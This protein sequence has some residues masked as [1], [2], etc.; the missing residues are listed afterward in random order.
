MGAIHWIH[1]SDLHYNKVGTQTD[2]MR[3]KLP[4]YISDIAKEH[5]INYIFF[6]GDIRFAPNRTF[7]SQTAD[8]FSSLCSAAGITNESLFAVIGNH[9][10]N[11]NDSQRLKAIKKLEKCYIENDSVIDA[12]LIEELKIGRQDYYALLRKI[13]PNEQY[14]LHSD[15]SKLHFTITTKDLNIVHVDST[16]MYT[17]AKQTDFFIGSYALKA[18]LKSCDKKKPTIILSHYSLDCFDPTEQKAI[19]LLLKDYNV[20]L[21][22]AGHKHT[23][24]I[25]KDRD[26]FYVAH[27]GNQTYEKLTTP[28]FVEGFLDTESGE[29]YFRVHKWNESSDWAVYQ[30]LTD[31]TDCRNT[32]NN[33][34]RTKYTF[35]LDDW[36]R[37]NGRE[38]NTT[39]PAVN[40]VLDFI[41][42][43]KGQSFF[44]DR[45]ITDLNLDKTTLQPILESLQSQGVIKPI[46]F[47]KTHWQ[48]LRQK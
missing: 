7:L 34:D 37:A 20:Q 46:N 29:G 44:F 32:T 17:E 9:D 23:D 38:K 19:L 5:E 39:N 40:Q 42:N 4:D 31:K 41:H 26:Y 33:L 35:T 11:R 15:P 16:I 43:F 10:V 12:A 24:I 22:L 25:H 27:S 18:A 28:G 8:Y 14:L 2:S 45:I 6:T 3:E 36:L 48:I 1:I 21:W 47:A 13:L 30:T